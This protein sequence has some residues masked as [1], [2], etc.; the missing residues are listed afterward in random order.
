MIRL[1]ISAEASDA[2]VKTLALGRVAV[3]AQTTTTDG[4]FIWVKKHAL[5]Q[6]C[7]LRQR[8]EDLSGVVLRLAKIEASR[9]GRRRRSCQRRTAGP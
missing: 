3:E 5:D 4:R 8:G 9:V 2:I 1:T 7:A 6:L